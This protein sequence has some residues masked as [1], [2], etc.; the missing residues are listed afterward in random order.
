MKT[1]TGKL[2][3]ALLAAAAIAAPAVVEARPG[4]VAVSGGHGSWQGGGRA[5]GWGYRGGSGYRGGWGRYRGG[6]GPGPFWGGLGIGLGFGALAYSSPYYG[7]YYAYPYPGYVVE[8]GAE[9]VVVDPAP[10]DRVV[11]S[12]GQPVPAATRAPDPIFYPK[13]GQTSAKTETDAQ[14]CNRWATT[15]TG[16][17]NDASIFQ[18]ATF[19]CME[20]R[21][22]TVR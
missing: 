21:G 10:G 1:M 6:W 12:S 3:A 9:Y 17:M 11:R 19:A 2:A 18:R 5:G 15:Q 14:E 8:P 16:A 13:N 4:G 7:G 20:G 22:Y